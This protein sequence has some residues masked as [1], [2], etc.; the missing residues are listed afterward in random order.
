MLETEFSG[1]IQQGNK[2]VGVHTNQGDFVRRLVVNAAGIYSDEVVHLAGEHPEFKISTRRGEYYIL[3]KTE[4]E[5]NKI[6][7]PVPTKTSKGILVLGSTHGN[8][9][10]DPNSEDSLSKED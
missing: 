1:V 4:I 7:F 3:D 6:L 10:V 2:I 8:V 5:M 9:V